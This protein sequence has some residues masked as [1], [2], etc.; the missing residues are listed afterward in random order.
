MSASDKIGNAAQD[1]AGKAKEAAGGAKDDEALRRE[2]QK[3]QAAA[4]LKQRG[5][6]LKDAFK[7]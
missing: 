6:H 5:E 7:G 2:G 3:D 1:L 4:D